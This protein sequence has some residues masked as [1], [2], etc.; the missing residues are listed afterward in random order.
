MELVLEFVLEFLTM[1]YDKE[2]QFFED[3]KLPLMEAQADKE[4]EVEFNKYAELGK[5]QKAAFDKEKKERKS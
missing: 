4:V 5:I 3:N 1:L 2:I